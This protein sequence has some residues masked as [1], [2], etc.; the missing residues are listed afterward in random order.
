M[1]LPD[2]IP[3]LSKVSGVKV[4][5]SET[6]KRTVTLQDLIYYS[7]SIVTSTC[8][9]Q[10]PLAFKIVFS[11]LSTCTSSICSLIIICV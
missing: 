1:T 2:E 5:A 11:E 9:F 6:R 10:N 3:D 8:S 7:S 4:I